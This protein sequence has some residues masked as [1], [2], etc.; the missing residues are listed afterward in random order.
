[1]SCPLH[2][3]P[4]TAGRLTRGSMWHVWHWLLMQQG[5]AAPPAACP[6]TC[7]TAGEGEEA[8]LPNAPGQA[9]GAAARGSG[10][11]PPPRL[12]SPAAG[13]GSSRIRGESRCMPCPWKPAAGYAPETHH[14]R[15]ARPPTSTSHLVIGICQPHQ[16]LALAQQQACSVAVKAA[17]LQGG[18]EH[19]RAARRRACHRLHRRHLLAGLH[20]ARAGMVLKGSTSSRP[21]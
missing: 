9:A 16:A 17:Q 18:V 5:H 10:S 12:P 11:G 8:A 21:T 14:A 15:R 2:V 20:K 13:M 6:I 7:T 4:M 19:A 1:M 3:I